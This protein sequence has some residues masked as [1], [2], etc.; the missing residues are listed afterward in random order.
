GWG[1]GEYNLNGDYNG[2][3]IL[4]IFDL[5]DP[6][7][8]RDGLQ[9]GNIVHGEWHHVAGTF[10]GEEI[11]VYIDGKEERRGPCAGEVAAVDAPLYIGTRGG[12]GRPTDGAYDEIRIYNRALDDEEIETVMIEGPV[13]LL[14]VDPRDRAAETWGELKSGIP[15]AHE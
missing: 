5:D 12:S 10:D 6:E 14:A 11:T 3:V 13:E 4:Q 15:K 2:A 9:V 8:C 7:G 1:A